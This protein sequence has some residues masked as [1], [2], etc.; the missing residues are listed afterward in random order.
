MNID[1]G[2]FRKRM[3]YHLFHSKRMY[4]LTPVI[5]QFC[6]F[7]GRDDGYHSRREH[8]AGVGGENAIDLL[9]YLQFRRLQTNSQDCGTK[10]G[11]TSPYL[12]E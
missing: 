11:I 4:D 9:P 8:F 12:P 10:V 6:R 2:W 7:L 1:L 5:S 3:W